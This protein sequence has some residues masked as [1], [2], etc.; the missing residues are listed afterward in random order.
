L[1]AECELPCGE[2]RVFAG[3]ATSGYARWN[4]WKTQGLRAWPSERLDPRAT[5]GAELALLLDAGHLSPFRVA[6]DAALPGNAGARR[7]LADHVLRADHAAALGS[8]LE[9]SR[10]EIGLASIRIPELLQ[11]RGLLPRAALLGW[12]RSLL[13]QLSAPAA[14]A[15]IAA[16]FRRY[17]TTGPSPR[18]LAELRTWR[19][20]TETVEI[21][22]RIDER[23]PSP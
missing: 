4:E 5:A 19:T 12:R 14:E 10:S 18:L 1:H 2:L 3:G 22:A 17:A 11:E 16:A 9:P 8:R 20:R 23:A 13:Q 7:W 21:P 15:C 6:R